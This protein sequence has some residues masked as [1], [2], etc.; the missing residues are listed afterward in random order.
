[1]FEIL[2]FDAKAS[3]IIYEPEHNKTNI[4]T[5][6]VPIKIRPSW[7]YAKSHYTIDAFFEV[8]IRSC[9][10]ENSDVHQGEYSKKNAPIVLLYNT[11][12][13]VLVLFI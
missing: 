9:Q 7:A 13:P 3:N 5:Y 2:L 8:N 11:V 1:M 10:P 4:A 12:S 6:W